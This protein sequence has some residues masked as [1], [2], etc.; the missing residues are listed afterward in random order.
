MSVLVFRWKR[1]IAVRV[2]ASVVL[3]L[4]LLGL[5]GEV[6]RRGIR[7]ARRNEIARAR[8]GAS[9]STTISTRL[10]QGELHTLR[11]HYSTE[12]STM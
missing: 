8:D 2:A 11:T 7:A 3:A 10:I 1:K 12:H 6:T 5:A 9:F 4:L